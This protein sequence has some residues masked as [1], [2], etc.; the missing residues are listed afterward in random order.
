MNQPY[1]AA[2]FDAALMIQVLIGIFILSLF[3][4]AAVLETVLGPDFVNLVFS[5]MG[6]K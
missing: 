2:D 4:A 6:V 1:T 5:W 3:L